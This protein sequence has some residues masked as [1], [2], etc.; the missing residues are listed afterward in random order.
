MILTFIE[1][2]ICRK[3]ISTWKGKKELIKILNKHK[4]KHDK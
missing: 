3:E 1:C 4:E 2:P